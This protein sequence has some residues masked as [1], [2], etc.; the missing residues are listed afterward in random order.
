MGAS[1]QMHANAPS[2]S[3]DVDFEHLRLPWESSQQWQLRRYAFFCLLN[4]FLR[5]TSQFVSTTPLGHDADGSSARTRAGI[6]QY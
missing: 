5:P 2:K 4:L 3:S 1:K 6:H